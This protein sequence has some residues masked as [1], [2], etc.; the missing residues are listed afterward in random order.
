MTG[1]E[2]LPT[3]IRRVGRGV[4]VPVLP[5]VAGR[6]PVETGVLAQSGENVAQSI[7]WR[8]TKRWTL[9]P[10]PPREEDIE[11]RDERVL[12]AG[13][14]YGHFGH[15]L[16]ES[17]AR[18]WAF[19]ALRQEIDRVVFVPRI[20][21]RTDRVLDF[22]RSFFDILDID[23]PIENL[24]TPTCF[25]EVFVPQQGIGIF[26]L[27]SGLPEYR[28]FMRS[29]VA[30]NVAA[31]GAERIY[32]SRSALPRGKGGLLGE[33]LIEGLFEREGYTVFHPQK[34]SFREQLAAYRAA[35]YIVSPDGSP[36]H[37]AALAVRPGTKIAVLARRPELAD[38]FDVQFRAFCDIAPLIIDAVVRHWVPESE[39]GP[40]RLSFG[41]LDLGVV[42][43]AL[44]EGGFVSR[45][46]NWPDLAG[47]VASDL[48]AEL[49]VHHK[50][51][52]RAH[53]S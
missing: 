22:Y 41:E 6:A 19:A 24:I 10:K 9:D 50:T 18:L 43:G 39:T 49:R 33:T 46:A 15:F 16:V 4:V 53:S 29:R 21:I 30:A 34:H 32:I 38:Q 3:R 52:F 44:K 11:Q 31:S 25:S 42:Q 1:S 5:G 13:L 23:R 51:G 48:V 26:N 35:D 37:M 20:Q 47:F 14:L 27:I 8:G 17:T 2:T 36:L 40:N 12:F 28:S 7:T 45:S